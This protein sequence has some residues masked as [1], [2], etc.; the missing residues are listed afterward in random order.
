MVK[1]ITILCDNCKSP[2]VQD[3]LYTGSFLIG[4]WRDLCV[5]CRILKGE[6][7]QKNLYGEIKYD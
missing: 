1:Y 2:I 7:V 4:E 3:V 5:S 6:D